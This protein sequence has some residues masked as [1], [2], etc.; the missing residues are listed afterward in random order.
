[1][2]SPGQR[3]GFNAKYFP[4]P[5]GAEQNQS[6]RGL[7][8]SKTLAR[9]L[10]TRIDA[11]AFWSAVV[12]YRFGRRFGVEMNRGTVEDTEMDHMANWLFQLKQQSQ[13]GLCQY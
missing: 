7:A 1:M 3:P 8:H 9:G 5:E 6:A 4:R 12:L 10:D 13:V 11:K 2:D